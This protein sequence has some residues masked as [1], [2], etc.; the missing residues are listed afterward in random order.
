VVPFCLF[1]H[2]LPTHPPPPA[3]GAPPPAAPR[4]PPPPPPPPHSNTRVRHT[5]WKRFYP[6][7][8]MSIK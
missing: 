3:G 1:S 8:V 6:E 4:P 7:N 2:R 5:N